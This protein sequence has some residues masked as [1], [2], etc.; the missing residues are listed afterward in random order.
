M[1]P[2]SGDLIYANDFCVVASNRKLK[3]SGLVAGDVVMVAAHRVAP[4][5]KK[6]P[7]LQRIYVVVML[8]KDDKLQVPG[9]NNN[10]TA[11]VVDPRNL[12]K[13]GP[14][15]QTLYTDKLREQYGQPRTNEGGEASN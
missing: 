8:F 14:L 1:T 13:L 2:L 4:H 7:Y 10:Y 12:Q 3:G 5:S 6:D 15:D 9:E 11:W